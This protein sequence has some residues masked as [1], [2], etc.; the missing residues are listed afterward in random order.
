MHSRKTPEREV[1]KCVYWHCHI[2]KR[3]KWLTAQP[4]A[5]YDQESRIIPGPLVLGLFPVVE[6][7][8]DSLWGRE[9]V[10]HLPQGK[11]KVHLPEME[12]PS[13]VLVAFGARCVACS[14]PGAEGAVA[15][16]RGGGQHGA[17][18]K[19]RSAFGKLGGQNRLKWKNARLISHPNERQQD[20]L[21]QNADNPLNY[22]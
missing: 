17:E 22:T 3:G 19:I 9:Q 18:S 2:K 16:R 21:R 10:K 4:D 5:E 1:W 20:N 6:V 11:F 13:Q 14:V 15:V 8:V 7:A 12:Q